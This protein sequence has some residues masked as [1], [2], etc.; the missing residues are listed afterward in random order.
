ML[1]LH[2]E[3]SNV[4][5]ALEWSQ[6]HRPNDFAGTLLNLSRYWDMSNQYAEGLRWLRA[7]LGIPEL[8]ARLRAGLLARAAL[9][10]AVCLDHEAARSQAE[11]CL[12]AYSALGDDAGAGQALLH[13]GQIKH[14]MGDEAGAAENYWLALEKLR[15]GGNRRGEAIVQINLTL[16]AFSQ[17]DFAAAETLLA[18]AS[19]LADELGDPN[20]AAYVTGLR[21]SLAYRRGNLDEAIAIN[22]DALAMRRLLANPSGVAEALDRM[23]A[24]HLARAEFGEARVMAAESMAI[25]IQNDSPPLLVDAFEAFAEVA[26]AQ[27][28]NTEAARCFASAQFLRRQHTYH[29]IGLRNTARIETDLRRVAEAVLEAELRD[30]ENA[31][32]P[33]WEQL[34][35]E[36]AAEAAGNSQAAS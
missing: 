8:P 12:D 16:L 14:R 21:A 2:A 11:A 25:A 6:L 7:G 28:R 30:L 22:R 34:G 4:R 32:S 29:H 31:G 10:A 33:R 13:L 15:S 1:R 19:A 20:V 9:F 5:A 23:V 36:L 18:R 26:L 3:L 24:I 17:Q 27:A 35:A